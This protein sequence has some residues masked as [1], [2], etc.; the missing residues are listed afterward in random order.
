MQSATCVLSS[1]PSASSWLGLNRQSGGSRRSTAARKLPTLCCRWCRRPMGPGSTSC[2]ERTLEVVHA[3]MDWGGQ[4][5]RPLVD[6]HALAPSCWD[7]P[8]DC[9]GHL[10][11]HG[12]QALNTHL[13]NRAREGCIDQLAQEHAILEG[14]TEAAVACM[15]H[16]KPCNDFKIVCSRSPPRSAIAHVCPDRCCF[17]A[18]GPRLPRV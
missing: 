11:H 2:C 15:R 14:S 9:I 5:R 4:Q 16:S 13:L 6:M 12:A 1:S 10:E 17:P 7:A 8:D 18:D 3:R